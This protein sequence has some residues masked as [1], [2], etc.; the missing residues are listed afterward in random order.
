MRIIA[1]FIL[2]I[3]PTFA[4]AQGLDGYDASK[5]L[6]GPTFKTKAPPPRVEAEQIIEDSDIVIQS[7]QDVLRQ[8]GGE[9]A[10][11]PPP[12]PAVKPSPK[13]YQTVHQQC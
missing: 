5:G 7:A 6:S 4:I 8:L 10:D 13:P 12:K 9:V 11:A 2:L 3:L 1:L